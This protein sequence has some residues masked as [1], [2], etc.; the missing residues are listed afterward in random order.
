LTEPQ[1]PALLTP[2]EAKAFYDRLGKLQDTQKFYERAALHDLVTHAAF[3]QAEAV[4]EFGCGTG[5]F[6][7]QLLEDHLSP[8]ATYLGVDIS[9]GMV[10]L[11]EEKL[12][13]FGDRAQVRLTQGSVRFDL[14]SGSLD[15]YVSNYVLDLLPARD[16][17][18]LI[19]EAHRLLAPGGKLCL[20]SLTHGCGPFS[21]FVSRVWAR[22]HAFSPKL[23]GGCR[24]V[25]LQD[26]VGQA[27]WH[28]D[29]VATLTAFA[30]PSEV[31]IASRLGE[32]EGN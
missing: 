3:E 10:R 11:A 13:R 12:A 27:Q 22:I 15:R 24:P 29:Y 2:E 20:V 19:Q 23:V 4:F 6:A 30:V 1:D 8:Q 28:I 32:Q 17:A 21:T 16:M 26:F 5:S 18:G 25:E 14:P 7:E 9:P 31:L